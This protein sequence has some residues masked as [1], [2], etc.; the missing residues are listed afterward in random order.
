MRLCAIRA[1]DDVLTLMRHGSENRH[2]GETRL[3][4]ESSR[5]HS[6]FTC[7]VE[8][9]EIGVLSSLVLFEGVCCSLCSYSGLS[10]RSPSCLIM[11]LTHALT[12]PHR[13]PQKTSKAKNGVTSVICSRLNL[14]DL[15]GAWQCHYFVFLSVCLTQF[16]LTLTHFV[17]TR[18]SNR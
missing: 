16:Q 3:N 17:Q 13:L 14:I 18:S 6:V 1:V 12:L 7:T 10:S 15:A 9:R 4:R 8:V 11:Q 2:T 5:S